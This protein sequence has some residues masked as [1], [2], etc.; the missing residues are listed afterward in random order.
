M[1]GEVEARLA[2]LGIEV[3]EAAAPVANYVGFVTS[4][5]LVFVSGQVP[6]VGG[7]F[8]FQGKVGA[9]FSLEQGQEAARI[10]AINIISQ[11]KT[12]TR[13]PEV[14]KPT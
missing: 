1:A 8:R 14:T 4:G 10:C 11:L 12:N 13:L 6:I 7:A 2:E 9:D 5:N 3:P